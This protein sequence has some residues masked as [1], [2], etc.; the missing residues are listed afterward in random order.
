M[1]PNQAMKAWNAELAHIKLELEP[2]KA[3]AAVVTNCKKRDKFPPSSSRSGYDRK[4][5]AAAIKTL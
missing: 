3:E 4:N 5:A 1:F 2:S